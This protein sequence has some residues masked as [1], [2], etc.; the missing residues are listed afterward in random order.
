M[1][2]L[3]ILLL[4]ICLSGC[5]TLNTVRRSIFKDPNIDGKDKINYATLIEEKEAEFR[6]YKEQNRAFIPFHM[7]AIV[8]AVGGI[9]LA[10][11]GKTTAD[12]GALAF[13]GGIALSSW[14]YLAPKYVAIPIVTLGAFMI[15]LA[16]VIVNEKI[17][18]PRAI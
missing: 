14:G 18:K 8:L 3:F 4:L 15:L 5:S 9:L 10:I 11:L 6:E 17:I 13:F 7:A 2:H 1:K 16:V 12:E